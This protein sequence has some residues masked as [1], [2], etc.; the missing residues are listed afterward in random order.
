M[1][2]IELQMMKCV[3]NLVC[4]CYLLASCSE[5]QSIKYLTDLQQANIKGHV[6]RLVTETYEV[7]SV[8][9]IGNL[10]SLTTEIFNKPG[11][12]I[13]DTTRNLSADDQVVNFLFY[14]GN[15]SL[16]SL[17]T[18]KNGKKQSGMSLKY[19]DERCKLINVYDS[20][21]KLQGYYDNISQTKHGLVLSLNSHDSTGRFIMSFVNEYDSIFQISATE[22]DSAGIIKSRV[23]IYLTDKKYRKEVL[24]LSYL[25]DSTVQEHLFYKYD[26]WD[27]AGN[28]IQQTVLDDKKRPIKLVKRFF[29]YRN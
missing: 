3:L 17:Q 4:I 20:N 7:D 6:V 13:T 9:Q 27:S 26:R 22:K 1:D 19:D 16:S 2:L 18:Y 23:K 29:Q 25:K 10:E 21:D 8:G 14:N 24:E 28:W 5:N 15:G 12:T 11:Y